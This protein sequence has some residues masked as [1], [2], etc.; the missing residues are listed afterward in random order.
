MNWDRWLERK[1]N[2]G[3]FGYNLTPYGPGDPTLGSVN[4]YNLLMPPAHRPD[5]IID[6][7]G[8]E[9]QSLIL[10]NDAPAPF[11]GGD[12]R[13]DYYGGDT[14][15]T[16]IGGAPSTVPGYGPDTR[17]LMRFQIGTTGQITELS[18]ADTIKALQRALPI[19]FRETQPP[20][21]ITPDTVQVK[22]LNETFDSYGRLWQRLGSGPGNTVTDY[23][24]ELGTCAALFL[25]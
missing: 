25:N 18:F 5:V 15:L 17:V 4:H 22:S 6:F 13:N 2:P 16:C 23:V 1:P 20:T 12:I 9:G 21:D 11:P 7:R 24:A 8:F 14:D 3:Q 19:T 10:Y